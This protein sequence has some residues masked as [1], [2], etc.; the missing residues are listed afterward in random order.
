MKKALV[1]LILTLTCLVLL[2]GCLRPDQNFAKKNLKNWQLHGKA[3]RAHY[4]KIQDEDT[5]KIRIRDLDAS[6]ETARKAV[7]K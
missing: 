2:T 1:G 7:K 3:A 4:E 6:I 5:K